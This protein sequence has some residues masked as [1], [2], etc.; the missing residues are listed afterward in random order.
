[1]TIINKVSVNKYWKWYGKNRSLCNIILFIYLV[2]PGLSCSMQDLSEKAMAIHSSVLAWKIPWTEKPDR[3][4]PMGSQRVRHAW[5]N[6][7]AAAAGSLIIVVASRTFSCGMKTF[8]CGMWDLVPWRRIEA[9]PTV[10]GAWS[11]KRWN[12]GE[13]SLC[14][15]TE[16]VAVMEKML[17][18]CS[19]E[20]LPNPNPGI[21][22]RSPTLWADSLLSELPK[23][24]KLYE[25]SKNKYRTTTWSSNTI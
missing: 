5:S 12:T 1:M 20:D 10:L 7:A 16:S 14:I 19:P 25:C 18:Y 3:L 6:L 2:V 17:C 8:S 22:P 13:V 24:P 9:R 21:E 23:K 15:V 11:L 4:Q